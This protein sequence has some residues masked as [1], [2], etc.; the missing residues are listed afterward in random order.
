MFIIASLSIRLVLCSEL[1]SFVKPQSYVSVPSANLIITP[2][3]M[4]VMLAPNKERH[5]KPESDKI[6]LERTRVIMLDKIF[7][8]LFVFFI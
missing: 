2:S 6:M 4:T 8:E 5:H 7:D 1:I 3:T